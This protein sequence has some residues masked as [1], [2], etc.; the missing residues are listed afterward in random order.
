MRS[1]YD[2]PD[3]SL[4]LP[5]RYAN[6][7]KSGTL[8]FFSKYGDDRNVD[9]GAWRHVVLSMISKCALHIWMSFLAQRRRAIYGID[10]F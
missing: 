9:R 5:I 8:A 4:P 2:F 6:Q 1:R 7:P 3:V 10:E